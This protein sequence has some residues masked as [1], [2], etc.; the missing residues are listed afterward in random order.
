MNVLGISCYFHDAAA[1]LLVDGKLI[2][3]A[4][5]E[6]F[7]RKKHDYEFPQ[8]AIDFCLRM[9][10]IDATDLDYVVFFE[11]PFVKFE[12]LLLSSM[13]TFPRSHRV[14]REAMITWLGDKLWIKHLIQ[15]RLGIAPTRILFSEHHL[16]HAASS[17]FC[18][19]FEEAA[20]L[21]VDGVGEWTTASIGI[22]KGTEI[23]LLKEIRFPHSIGLLYSAF[24]AFLGFEVNEGEY[25]VMGM[26][27][28]GT[29]K[30]VDKV[31]KLIRIGNDG[32]FELD[33]DY[34][35]FHYSTDQTFNGKFT[36]LFGP[37][38]DPKAYFFTPTSGYP[39]YFGEKPGN[40]GE[41]AKQNQYYADVAA[42]IQAVTEEAVLQLAKNAYKETGLKQ[43]CM[44]G[45]VALN[46]VANARILRE[47]PFE[48]LYIQPSAGDGGGALG[49]AL[50]GYHAVLG[51]PR[52]FV[53]EH[54]YWGEEH[55][56]EAVQK[57][58]E[59]AGIRYRH[60]QDEDKLIT[61]VV[62]RLQSGKVIGWSQG[63]FEWGPRAL[64][65]RSIL[66]DPR[67]TDMKDIVNVKIKFREPFRPF[68]PSILAERAEEY[69]TLPQADKQYPARFM[70]YVVDVKEEKRE[71]LPAITHVDGTGRL[72]T[73][74]RDVS[75]KYYR[76]IETFGE[77][78]G[79]PVVLNT[80]FNLKGEPIVN[81]PEEAFHT[82][83]QSGMDTLVLGEYVI[84][85]NQE[86]T[87]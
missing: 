35:C 28:F 59:N 7:T 50:Y 65:S 41:L 24:T 17:F 40:Y 33:L 58:L 54:A 64:G 4:E 85:K 43:L 57:F 14:F 61:Y 3:A 77:A 87:R 20:I 38:R 13:Q 48:R 19:P 29:P 51:K 70:L 32:S 75:P 22:G 15:K 79:T 42:S 30:Y 12:R 26:A 39:S 55:S 71:V 84:E 68:A 5:E 67:R 9:G 47:T 69:F 8:R 2:A 76:L 25:K 31:H 49:A 52:N 46:S 36:D 78:T 37:S 82:F 60:F 53:M 63:R 11:K 10:R 74:C 83:S 86:V 56:P 6:R 1:A 21:S 27:P 73:V 80:S 81:T 16:S 45:G 23:R 72:Q 66:A 62:D 18:S 44:A 34:F